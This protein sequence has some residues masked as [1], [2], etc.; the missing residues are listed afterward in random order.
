VRED[1]NAL[2]DRLAGLPAQ[3]VFGYCRISSS[4]QEQGLSLPAQEDAIRQYCAKQQ[5]GEPVIVTETSTAGRRMFSLPRVAPS[6]A[7]EGEDDEGDGPCRPRLLL[8]LGHITALS[9]AH[10]VVWRLD[11]LARINDEREVIHQLLLRSE[12]KLHTTDRSEQ[13]WLDTGDPND[14][15]AALMRQVFGAFSQYEKAVIEMRMQTG[16][17]FK[18]ARGGYTG[19]RHPFGF[20]VANGELQVNEEDAKLIRYLFMLSKRYSM[21]LRQIQEQL[22]A[23]GMPALSK[24]KIHRIL[25][26]EPIYR[27]T[28]RDRFGNTHKR[29]DLRILT[30]SGDYNYEEEFRRV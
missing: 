25:H 26:H 6:L 27:G 14:P 17:R 20:S 8:L 3:T 1:L 29:P 12:V 30:D 24:T 10:L 16:M 7:V 11:R 18:A 13:V 28:Y 23:Y 22:T 5:L 15:M 4:K 9:K 19:G 21:S 2:A